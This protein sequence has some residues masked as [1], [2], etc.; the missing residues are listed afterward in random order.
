MLLTLRIQLAHISKPP[1]WRKL[2]VPANFT[3]H[4]LH[5]VI[6]AAFGWHDYHMYQFSEKGY[7]SNETISLPSDDDWQEVKNSKKIKLSGVFTAARQ[8]YIYIY[9]FGDNWQHNITV[10][11]IEET[12]ASKAACIEGKGACPPED[13]GGTPGYEDLKAIMANPKHAEY[14]DMREWMGLAPGE[15]WNPAAFDLQEANEAV[16]KV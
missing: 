1:V 9:D 8:K 3:F 13:C 4:K 11:E 15:V 5:Q 7:G 14:E 6:Q 12:T 10:E 16:K 2:T